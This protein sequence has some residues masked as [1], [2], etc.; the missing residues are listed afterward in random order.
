MPESFLDKA[1]ADGK[2]FVKTVSLLSS[3]SKAKL[4]IRSKKREREKEMTA[5]GEHV[6]NSYEKNQSI[7]S[8]AI[9]Q[10]ITKNLQTIATIDDE[11]EKLENEIERLKSSFKHGYTDDEEDEKEEK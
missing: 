11:L 4:A 5:I 1:K 7:D 10:G 6:F 9:L 8:E 3:M 2:V